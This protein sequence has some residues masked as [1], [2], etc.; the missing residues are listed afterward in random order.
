[1]RKIVAHFVLILTLGIS[2]FAFAEL[3]PSEATTLMLREMQHQPGA[4]RPKLTRP[5]I[6]RMRT[7]GLDEHER[8]LKG[9][10][11]FINFQP[12]ESRDAFWPFRDHDSD[13]GRVAWQR[14][15][16]IR[17]NAYQM[18]EQL[19]DNDIPRYRKRFGVSAHDRNGISYPVMQA[20]RQ[21]AAAGKPDQALD[22]IVEEVRLHDQ[23]DAPYYAYQLPGFFSEIASE[24]D[25]GDE[26]RELQEWILQGLDTAIEK[27]LA[28]T[29]EPEAKAYRLPGGTFR[30]LFEDDVLSYDDW[31]GEFLAMRAQLR[32]SDSG[33]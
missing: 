30:T 11:H 20:A 8:F 21:L 3:A 22:M 28:V 33:T 10:A 16:I 23:F 4:E 13:L 14:I 25:R 31:T 7:E 12:E 24:N 27:R 19:I 26:F 9:E 2:P 17:I 6:A 5:I 29:P 15:M 32:N 1:M 18:L